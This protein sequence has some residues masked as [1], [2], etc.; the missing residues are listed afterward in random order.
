L[1]QGQRDNG[2]FNLPL[3]VFGAC[4]AAALYRR[5]MLEHLKEETG[6]FDERFFFLVEDVDLAWRAKKQGWKT[7]FQPELVCYHYGNSSNHEKNIRQQL[8]FRNRFYTI[9]KN[10]GMCKYVCK[11]IPLLCY[12]FPRV[13]YLLFTNPHM[14]RKI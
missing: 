5:K 6:Y 3:R 10:E 11:I 4:S 13:V 2:K 1:G 9:K 14:F 12:D 7:L 8:S